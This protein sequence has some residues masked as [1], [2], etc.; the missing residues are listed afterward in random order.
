MDFQHPGIV[1]KPGNIVAVESPDN[2][3]GVRIAVVLSPQKWC[4]DGNVPVML[5][6]E[7][8]P[9]RNIC[10]GLDAKDTIRKL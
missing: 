2:F 5:A 7:D 3:K 1:L 9:I 4:K 8:E 6:D 10:I